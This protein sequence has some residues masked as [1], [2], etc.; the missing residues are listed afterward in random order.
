MFE[1]RLSAY[2]AIGYARSKAPLGFDDP[3]E[4]QAVKYDEEALRHFDRHFSRDGG[5]K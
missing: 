3:P 1:K 4:G 2:R 5:K